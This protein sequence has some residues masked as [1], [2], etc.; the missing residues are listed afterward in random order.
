MESCRG[1]AEREQKRIA[2]LRNFMSWAYFKESDRWTQSNNEERIIVKRQVSYG[3]FLLALGMFTNAAVYFAFFVGI[4]DFRTTE[5]V[6]MRRVP[7]LLKFG[8]SSLIA[9]KM[10]QLLWVKQIYEPDLYRV[11]LKYRPYYDAEFAEKL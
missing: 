11:A 7:F 4:Y 1:A 9:Y 8:A 6:N 3:K 5:L 2:I 10:C